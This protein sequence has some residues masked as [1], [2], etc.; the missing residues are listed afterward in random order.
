MQGKLLESLRGLLN[1]EDPVA[2]GKLLQIILL[3]MPSI[4][5]KLRYA[6]S[7]SNRIIKTE[8]RRM[9]KEEMID[10]LEWRFK[11]AEGKFFPFDNP[12]LDSLF[13]A[14]KGNPRTICGIAQVALELAGT[15]NQAITPD[16][17]KELASRRVTN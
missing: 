12:T 6:P 14:S 5:R 7:F 15:T 2:G 16:I 17:I 3:A 11:Q 4:N 9:T 8:L 13:S 1:F 10:M